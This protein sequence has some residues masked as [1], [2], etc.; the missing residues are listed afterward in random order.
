MTNQLL[1]FSRRQV[2]QPREIDLNA[3]VDGLAAM[4]RRILE[5]SVTLETRLRPDLWPVTMDRGQMEQVVINLAVNARDAMPQ[6][7]TLTIETANVHADQHPPA[8]GGL[9]GDS[10]SV[11][12]SDTGVGMDQETVAR[13]F[14]PFFTTRPAGSGSGLGLSTVYGIVHQNKGSIQVSTEPGRGS[15]FHILLPRLSEVSSDARR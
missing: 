7:G 14:E 15:T 5:P 8:L 10:V 3:L 6:G 11:S 12:V 9:T 13:I 2:V 4:L 1:A